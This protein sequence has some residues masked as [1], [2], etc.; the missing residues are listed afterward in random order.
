MSDSSRDR[1][2]SGHKSPFSARGVMD[3]VRDNPEPAVRNS[4]F[5]SATQ[6]QAPRTDLGL[7]SLLFVS[8]RL[9]AP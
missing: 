2:G 1:T 9:N 3:P 8:S 7:G 4:P 5:H 6:F